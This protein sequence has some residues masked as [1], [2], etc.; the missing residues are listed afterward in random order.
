MLTAIKD[1]GKSV[2]RVKE[3]SELEKLVED[4]EYPNILAIR[5]E[6][7]SDGGWKYAGMKI[8]ERDSNKKNKYLY[9]RGSSSGI[10]YSPAAKLTDKK[11]IRGTIERKIIKWFDEVLSSKNKSYYDI[12]DEDENFLSSIHEELKNNKEE[13]IEKTTKYRE[14]IPKKY[15]IV[16]IL[17]FEEDGEEKY[18]G[19]YELFEELLK[20]VTKRKTSNGV[21]E[22]KVCSMCGNKATV[23]AGD[24]IYR[25]YTND[26]P[27]YIAGGFSKRLAWR[28]FPLCS[29]CRDFLEE[30]KKYIEQNL[31]FNFYGLKYRLIPKKLFA[32]SG[33]DE[34]LLDIFEEFKKKVRLKD[35]TINHITDN[36]NEILELIAEQKDFMLIDFLFLEISN[37]AERILLHIEDVLPSRL[38]KIFQAKKTVDKHFSKMFKNEKFTFGCIRRFLSKSDD[39]KRQN[40]LDK[41]FL[42]IT[43]SVFKGIPISLNFLYKIIM[44]KIRN[45]FVNDKNTKYSIYNAFLVLEFLKKLSLIDMEVKDVVRGNFEEFFERFGESIQ[46]PLKRGLFLLGV[47]TELLLRVQYRNL[48]NDP[49]RKTLKGLKMQEKD[50][51]GLLPKVQNKFSEYESYDKGKQEIA[52]EVSKYLLATGDDWNMSIDEMNFYFAAGMN[53]ADEITKI[54]YPEKE[55]ETDE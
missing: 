34:D 35:K 3:K 20:K 22:D 12:S 2:L 13:I 45:E 38:Q 54:V 53:L 24:G 19:D 16:V 41:Y 31:T 33:L 52:K 51:K 42:D 47:L 7:Q 55:E 49:F 37:S 46:S 44:Q 11:K 23:S 9:R 8:E 18:A 4:I 50:F 10:N 29:E 25:F 1:I 21:T 17:K 5:F 14:D 43:N 39:L 48:G 28:N 15:G 30:G 26:K 27:G 36:E 32:F 40:D 6:K